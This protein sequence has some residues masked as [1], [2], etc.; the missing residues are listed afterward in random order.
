MTLRP[1]WRPPGDHSVVCS[2][3]RH[4]QREQR[5]QVV[6]PAATAC[7]CLLPPP[8]SPAGQD[9]TTLRLGHLQARTCTAIAAAAAGGASGSGSMWP[10]QA[11]AQLQRLRSCLPAC[12]RCCYCRCCC[13]QPRS[14]STLWLA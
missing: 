12:R 2:S 1:C 10:A 9:V 14:S 5:C 6:C 7:L 8:S 4:P 11:A 3:P 13:S